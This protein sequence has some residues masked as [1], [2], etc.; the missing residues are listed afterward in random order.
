LAFLADP[1]VLQRRTRA[2]GAALGASAA[3]PRSLSTVR[4]RASAARLALYQGD[5]EIADSAFVECVA[6]QREL[7]DREGAAFTIANRSMVAEAR[8]EY[9]AASSLLREASP[10][11]RL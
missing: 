3:A 1:G 8:G 4:A 6:I 11:L 5:H 10:R 7:N 9:D 2:I